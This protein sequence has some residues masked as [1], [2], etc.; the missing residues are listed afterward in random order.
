MAVGVERLQP[1]K[2]ALH[3]F[4]RRAWS[5]CPARQR[6]T[7][8]LSKV[9]ERGF[10]VG[11]P[12]TNLVTDRFCVLPNSESSP[13]GQVLRH[14]VMVVV[15]NRTRGQAGNLPPNRTQ[16]H[17]STPVVTQT[18]CQPPSWT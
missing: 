2:P 14:Q 6:E 4:A 18:L 16:S 17:S 13:H 10:H 15:V 3:R 11:M 12:Y 8:R 1:T 7:D 9:I 5:G